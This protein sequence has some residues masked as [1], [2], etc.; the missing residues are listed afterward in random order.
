MEKGKQ[1]KVLV[2]LGLILFF[3][4][5][6]GAV[7]YYKFQKFEDLYL[8]EQA[9]KERVRS[10]LQSKTTEAENLQSEVDSTKRKLSSTEKELVEIEEQ[11]KENQ[12]LIEKQEKQLEEQEEQ[13]EEI[14]EDIEKIERRI[15][16]LED[17]I[18]S[19]SILPEDIATQIYSSCGSPLRIQGDFCYIDTYSM[20]K[21][22]SG[23]LGF[24]WVDDLTTSGD[25]QSL[26]T[27]EE[28]WDSKEGDCDDFS[29]FTSAWLRY[30]I[31]N[32]SCSNV[33]ILMGNLSFPAA[34]KERVYN[35]CGIRSGIG[36]HCEV[37]YYTGASGNP[38]NIDFKDVYLFEPQNGYY[39]GISTMEFD[40]GITKFFTNDNF[41]Y[42]EDNQVINS[43]ESLKE[44]LLNL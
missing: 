34:E 25:Y 8:D 42:V 30:E 9:E 12:K 4:I 20:G 41:Y 11:V 5:I 14:T 10:Q 37:G 32:A 33:V 35:I 23:C 2:I 13:L 26:F 15:F 40:V 1:R 18:D 39:R 21:N 3:S 29:L 6:F 22:M 31:G 27:I 16:Y 43:L 36:G 44:K 28:F 7:N 17:F 24:K 19:N 38:S